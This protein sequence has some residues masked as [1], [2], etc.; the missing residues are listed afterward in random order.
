MTLK[1][2]QRGFQRLF[3]DGMAHIPP[4]ITVPAGMLVEFEGCDGLRY[5]GK[6]DPLMNCFYKDKGKQLTDSQGRIVIPRGWRWPVREP[7]QPRAGRRR[8]AN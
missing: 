5:L 7:K 4:N 2:G 3:P 6:Y 8:R 1:A